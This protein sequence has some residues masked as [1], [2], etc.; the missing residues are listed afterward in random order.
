MFKDDE[1]EEVYDDGEIGEEFNDIYEDDV[2][3]GLLEDVYD[4]GEILEEEEYYELELD[5][6]FFFFV[7]LK[8]WKKD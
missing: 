2:E 4:D 5:M 8:V 6:L 7:L 3:V 1:F